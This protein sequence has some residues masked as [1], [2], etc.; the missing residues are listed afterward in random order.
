LIVRGLQPVAGGD[1]ERP[2]LL[3]VRNGVTLTLAEVSGQGFVHLVVN[4]QATLLDENHA[5]AL[6]KLL[7]GMIAEIQARAVLR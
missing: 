4:G 7:D 5:A 6:S 1:P 2:A 3:G